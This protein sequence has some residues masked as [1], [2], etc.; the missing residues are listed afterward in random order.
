MKRILT[1]LLI[2]LSF[3]Q[4]SYGQMRFGFEMQEGQNVA[5]IPIAMVSNLV[6]LPVTV[7][8]F[9]S[10]N[11]VLDTGVE[12]T[13]LT[14]PDYAPLMGV[15]LVRQ[16]TISGAGEQDS[17]KAFLG[18]GLTLELPN[19]IVGNNIDILVLDENYLRL[20]EQMGIKVHGIIGYEIFKR[21]V[22]EIDYDKPVLRLYRPDSYNPP[23]RSQKLPITFNGS[24]KPYLNAVLTNEGVRDTVSLMIDSGASHALLL[25]ADQTRIP[26][27]SRT[28]ETQLGTGL[29]GI[30]TGDLGR[31]SNVEIGEYDFRDVIVSIPDQDD[32]NLAIKRG[33]RH[34]TIGGEIL[35][36]LNPVFDYQ[37]QMVYFS[38]AKAFKSYFDYDMSGMYLISQGS[39][40]DSLFVS[41]VRP[42]SPADL[43]GIQ[44]GDQ[45]LSINSLNYPPTTLNAFTSMLRKRPGKKITI[46]VI[47]EGR[48]ERFT[49]KLKRPI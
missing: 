21:F 38:K 13:I 12:T 8:K 35:Y 31:V 44:R 29:G 33:A 1:L 18:Q 25:D 10:L 15:N 22:V 14:E 41:N 32:Y 40:L 47:R 48:R 39:F 43:A 4:W 23:R 34:G 16:I 49:F 36:R 7:N 19:G 26:R 17:I 2:T 5:E 9:L 11:F 3:S 24:F 27:P 20:S 28:I 45:I 37:N 42:E 30:I 46:R 6:I